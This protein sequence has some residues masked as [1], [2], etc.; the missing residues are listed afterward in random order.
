M[1]KA[2]LLLICLI[3][4]ACC[5]KAATVNQKQLDYANAI[6]SSNYP[7]NN[8][9]LNDSGKIYANFKINKVDENSDV[10]IKEL[11][12]KI[13]INAPYNIQSISVSRTECAD[14]FEPININITPTINSNNEFTI[15][16]ASLGDN[17]DYSSLLFTVR[18]NVDVEATID[19]NVEITLTNVKYKSSTGDSQYS[20]SD[21]II[22]T[23]IIL[24]SV[25]KI[26]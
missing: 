2:L 11:S 5:V 14:C 8:R 1:K 4:S 9:I 6:I 21:T 23:V 20:V 13:N 24:R 15:N 18:F 7:I 12:G 16:L 25:D 19:T 17:F 26:Q 3:I 22:N 10:H